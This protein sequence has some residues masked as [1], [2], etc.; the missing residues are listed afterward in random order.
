MEKEAMEFACELIHTSKNYCTMVANRLEIISH[1]DID[2]ER[3]PHV[4]PFVRTACEQARQ[5]YEDT[6]PGKSR[7]AIGNA[8]RMM[9]RA[10]KSREADHFQAAIGL[11]SL[12]EG[13]CPPVPD[14]AHDK[15][16]VTGKRLGR[17][18]D[19]FLA[20]GAK[21]VPPPNTKDAYEDEAYRLWK[22]KERTRVRARAVTQADQVAQLDLQLPDSASQAKK[23]RSADRHKEPN[24][25]RHSEGYMA[26]YM[27]RRR[28]DKKDG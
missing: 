11:R 6:K 27:R 5:W 1:E 25:D 8:I 24:R 19:H 14:R 12:L 4:V 21:L 3:A 22:L 2:T 9:S 17:G 26:D 16:T 18:L 23:P 28:A 15:H 13:Y 7:M 10:P 20:E